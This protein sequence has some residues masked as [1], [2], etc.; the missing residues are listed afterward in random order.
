ML[1]S[2]IAADGDRDGLPNVLLEAGAMELAAVASRVA[3][4]PE[5]IADGVNGRLVPPDDPPALAAALAGADRRSGAAPAARPRRPGAGAG[6]ASRW[7][8]APIAW[9]RGCGATLAAGGRVAA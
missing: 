7:A 2:R 9:R 8:P 4:I 3:A 1:A 6:R 5:L